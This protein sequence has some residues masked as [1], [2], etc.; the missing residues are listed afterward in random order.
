MPLCCAA[1]RTASQHDIVPVATPAE[2]LDDFHGRDGWRGEQSGI[3]VDAEAFNIFNLTFKVGEGLYPSTAAA[4]SGR[5][6][7]APPSGVPSYGSAGQSTTPP[8]TSR[9]QA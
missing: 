7:D 5:R 1:Q 3:Y 9:R 6:R 8:Q 2:R 4:G